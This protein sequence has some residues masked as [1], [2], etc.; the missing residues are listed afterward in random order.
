MS[1]SRRSISDTFDQY[2]SSVSLTRIDC[3]AA[4]LVQ[5]CVSTRNDVKVTVHT[6][7]QVLVPSHPC[8]AASL[9]LWRLSDLP[10][11]TRW[12]RLVW[13]ASHT[14][15][16]NTSRSKPFVEPRFRHQVRTPV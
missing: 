2:L 1:S 13:P 9:P 5:G 7:G 4:N 6:L 15:R 8:L 16:S 10:I 12:E 14:A 3:T 11:P